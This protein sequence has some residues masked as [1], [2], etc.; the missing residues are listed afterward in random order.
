M[1]SE[2]RKDYVR[3]RFESAHKT[4]RAAR[5][6]GDNGFW[7]SAVNRLY[8]AACYAVNA[9]LTANE[10][11]ARSHSGVK[12]QFSLHFIKTK[13]LAVKYGQLF[14]E[15]FDWRQKGDYENL[16][17]FDEPSV[18]PLFDKVEEFIAVIEREANA[19]LKT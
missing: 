7:N 13:K 12:N 10:I 14:S 16:F 3:Y 8:Y 15:L 1:T 5:V 9:L 6:L 17:D 2:E 18:A 4:M 19:S 11:H